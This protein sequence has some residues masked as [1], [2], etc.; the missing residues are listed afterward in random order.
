M[1]EINRL[2][3][4]ADD[5]GSTSWG[6]ELASALHNI[7]AGIEEKVD[8][9]RHVLAADGVEVHKGDDVWSTTGEFDGKRTVSSVHIDPDEPPYA[10]FEEL[11]KPYSC[12]CCYLTRRAPVLAADGEPLEVGQTVYVIA[13]GKT[14]HVTEVDAVSKRFRSMEQVDG[15]HWLDPMCFTHQRPVLGADGVPIKKG[16]TV[17]HKATGIKYRVFRF[18]A[19]ENCVW[20]DSDLG[21][22]LLDCSMLTNTKPEPSDSWEKWSEDF[23]KPPCVYCRDI[24]GVEFDD[25]TELDKAFDAQV[26]DM[27]RR[28]RALAEK[29]D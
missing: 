12:L 27:E 17:W 25:D 20:G 26:Q 9:M 29:E 21:S 22:F 10:M 3:D 8:E 18:S 28:A 14:H 11:Q 4:I 16:D 19:I 5:I 15:S 23:I 24:L 2:H 7:A 6:Y 13:N 1:E